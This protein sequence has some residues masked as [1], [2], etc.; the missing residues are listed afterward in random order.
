MQQITPFSHD[1]LMLLNI[2]LASVHIVLSSAMLYFVQNNVVLPSYALP[3]FLGVSIVACV[4]I[5]LYSFDCYNM[6]NM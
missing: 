2:I 5:L 1:T 3:G 4:L 6:K